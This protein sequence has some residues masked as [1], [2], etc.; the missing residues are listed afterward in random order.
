MQVNAGGKLLDGVT[1]Q[2]LW[3]KQNRGEKL[4]EEEELTTV[5]NFLE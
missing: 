5:M 1:G 3:H 4:T 2:D